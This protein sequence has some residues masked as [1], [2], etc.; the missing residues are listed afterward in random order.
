MAEQ[1]AFD[2][3]GPEFRYPQSPVPL[4]IELRFSPQGERPVPFERPRHPS[5]SA[6]VERTFRA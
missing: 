2:P 4:A 3:H 1:W 6:P 5:A